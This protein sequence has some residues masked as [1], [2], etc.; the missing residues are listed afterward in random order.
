MTGEKGRGA[1]RYIKRRLQK[2][3]GV[4]E[5]LKRVQSRALLEIWLSYST[6]LAFGIKVRDSR[7]GELGGS[8]KT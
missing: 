8:L 2:R 7:G 3:R 1:E 6:S 4:E 5:K